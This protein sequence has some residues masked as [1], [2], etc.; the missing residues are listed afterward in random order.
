MIAQ[1]PT[2]QL[3]SDGHALSIPAGPKQIRAPWRCSSSVRPERGSFAPAC[4][5]CAPSLL[6]PFK[7]GPGGCEHDGGLIPA[8]QL[9]G[10]TQRSQWHRCSQVLRELLAN[11]TRDFRA[12]RIPREMPIGALAE[13]Q[14]SRAP[15]SRAT[16]HTRQSPNG[17]EP[18]GQCS[19]APTSS[20]AS[21]P[22]GLLSRCWTSSAST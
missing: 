12:T 9:S 4:R 8:G 2:M 22:V 11:K 1:T 6:R 21:M 18:R 19:M 17:T 7:G 16:S 13:R 5:L 20:S 10:F 14:S 3:S 15:Q